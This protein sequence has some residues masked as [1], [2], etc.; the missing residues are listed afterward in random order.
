MPLNISWL[1]NNKKIE[2]NAQITTSAI[3]KRGSALS[4]ESV[5]HEHA[6]KYTCVAKNAAGEG[7]YSADLQVNSYV[8][9]N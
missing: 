3:G 9:F 8:W 4:M 7:A 6:G 2:E 1:L 5:S